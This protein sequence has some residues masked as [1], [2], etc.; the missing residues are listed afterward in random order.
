MIPCLWVLTV[1]LCL[2]GVSGN[3]FAQEQGRISGTVLDESKASVPGATITVTNDRTGEM[4][5]A[6]SK[7]DG[8][9]S[10][11]GLRPSMYTVKASA[12]QFSTAEATGVQVTV[13]LEIHQD[14][15][16][17]VAAAATSVTVSSGTE[18]P[19]DTTSA[20]IG[21]NVTEREVG[22]LPI[23]GRQLSQL[24]LQAPG[25][26]NAGSGNFQDIRFS[27]KATDQ[28][29]V[30][31]DGIEGGAVIDA[32]PGNL[33]GE[34]PSPFKLQSSLE[35]VQEFR[36]ESNNYPAEYGTG[37]GGQISV[38]T[39]SG[40]NA[41][42]GAGY[43][44]FRNDKLDAK[45]FFDLPTSK[46]KLR[47]NQFGAS[48]GGPL[49]KDKLFFFGYYEGY[50]L[51]AGTNS[52]ESSPSSAFL[53]LPDCLTGQSF[54][55][56]QCVNHDVKQLLPG[57]HSPSA[58]LIQPDA[59]VGP[60]TASSLDVYQMV[61]SN[62]VNENSFGV[63]FDYH[64]GEKNSFYLRAFRD[65]ANNTYPEGVSGRTVA[66]RALP[67]NAVAGWT[68]TLTSNVVNDFKV[69]Y[70]GALTRINGFAPIINGIDFSQIAI[71]ATGSITLSGIA[72]QGGSSAG[73]TVPGGLVRSNSATNGRGTP[74]TP[75]SLSFIDDLSWLRG[76]HSLKFGV[77][78]RAITLHTDRL[79]GTTY[80][81][82]NLTNLI[83]GALSSA[84]NLM[85]ESAPSPYNN[86][87]TGERVMKQQY[88]IG[89][90]QDEIKLK[91]N[92]TLNIGLR[93]EYYTQLHEQ[94]DRY[95]FFNT[96]TGIMTSPNF[97]YT[98]NPGLTGVC[99][100]KNAPWYKTDP[101]NFGPRVGISWSPNSKGAG[102]FGGGKTVIRTGFGVF[103]GPGQ[104]E[105]QLQPGESDRVWTTPSFSGNGTYCGLAATCATSPA[106]LTAN[107]LAN[108]NNRSARVRTYDPNMLLP[109]RNYQYST[110]W[111]QQWPGG[112]VST[113]AYVGSQ[114]R[115]L[116]VRNIAN[117]IVAVRTNPANGASIAIREFDIDCTGAVPAALPAACNNTPG[118]TPGTATS[119]LHPYAEVDFKSSGGHDSYNAL[120]TQLLRRFGSGLSLSAQYTYSKSFGNSGGSNESLTTANPYDYSADNGYNIFDLR[121]NFNVSA[122][123]H[124]P[125]GK[126]LNGFAKEVVGNWEV[127][128]IVNVR[129][130]FPV[131]VQITRPDVAFQAL[132][133]VTF[134]GASIAG[135]TFNGALTTSVAGIA[136]CPTN[137]CTVA[138]I[139]TIGGGNT[140]N[141]RRPDVVPGV[142]QWLPN[143]NLNPAAFTTPAP[144]T[145][146]NLVRNSVHG[147]AFAQTDIT[148]V[149]RFPVRESVSVEFRTEV[150]N[151][152][153]HV[154]FANPPAQLPNVLAST[155][156]A[157]N[158]LQ[159]G[160]AFTS[161]A[162]GA[163][164]KRNS[165]VAQ[166]VGLGTNRQ[167]QFGLRLNF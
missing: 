17:R 38:V 66:I 30:R 39:K 47:Q 158:T 12:P 132:P 9:Y 130:G 15:T 14:F 137:V 88:Y 10:L 155:P 136:G 3:A 70:N 141:V 69:G 126:N 13:G 23:N 49:V 61:G 33:S 120:Q 97:C 73:L 160:Q 152:F 95:V 57:F 116:F 86:G 16:L 36:V 101:S 40:S 107:F 83:N 96:D 21:I 60:L 122:L 18:T 78:V 146:G 62:N 167:I 164:G 127:G 114:G 34:T 25:A 143:G 55:T 153:N 149:K 63:R 54:P 59:T 159:P 22:T 147:P 110:S 32:A 2:A 102:M 52:I 31:Y 104:T 129:S 118:F 27:G 80:S 65:Q 94:N 162:A 156:G 77:E 53:A 81:F 19:I 135:Q 150:F 111:Q 90:V 106:A 56:V 6:I 29:A 64:A 121:H 51:R 84:D 48:L 58:I 142:D 139:N 24:V 140:R 11:L 148:V 145:F 20:R 87:V 157:T 105:D 28:N 71:N 151:L 93:Y 50:R 5:T 117:R 45:N 131:P 1:V 42:H 166:T 103:T 82:S 144:G 109:E 154:N 163:F 128:T 75:Y 43:E 68:N 115:N 44:Y 76:N 138:V 4:H 124:I 72:G 125:F 113:I 85:D 89:Y 112:F 99:Q 165:T 134:N 8:S 46:S 123:Y 91:P 26:T 67:Q 100:P 74:Y 161:A 119:I 92:L 79:G 98:P 133:G 41:F 35:N 7:Q 108:P 37:A